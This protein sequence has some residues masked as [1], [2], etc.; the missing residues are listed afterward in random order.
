MNVYSHLVVGECSF[1]TLSSCVQLHTSF[2]QCFPYCSPKAYLSVELKRH[3]QALHECQTRLGG[4]SPQTA[5]ETCART[6]DTA[7]MTIFLLHT[8]TTERFISLVL[9][10]VISQ[11]HLYLGLWNVLVRLSKVMADFVPWSALKRDCFFRRVV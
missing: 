5:S 2:S 6:V 9:S 8:N 4:R 10:S 7:A 11:D 1:W 3:A